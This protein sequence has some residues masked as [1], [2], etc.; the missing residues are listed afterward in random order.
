MAQGVRAAFPR[1]RGNQSPCGAI[2]CALAQVNRVEIR[3]FGS[4]CPNYQPA[5]TGRK[6]RTGVAL[7]VA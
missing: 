6:P 2:G 3:S 5:R 7:P 1:G 4:F